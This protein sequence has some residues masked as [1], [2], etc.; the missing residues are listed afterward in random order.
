MGESGSGKTTP[1]RAERLGAA[2]HGNAELVRKRSLAG[3]PAV[4]RPRRRPSEL[5][6]DGGADRREN[7]EY[8]ARLAK[9]LPELAGRVDEL[10][11]RSVSPTSPT[12]SPSRPRSASSSEPRSRV[13]SSSHRASCSPTS[14]PVIRTPAG[15]SV[16]SSPC[17]TR[18]PAA[19]PVSSPRTTRRGPV[20]RHGAH[21]EQRPPR[22]ERLERQEPGSMRL[23]APYWTSTSGR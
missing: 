20:L 3:R 11:A 18:R 14:R 12:G 9:R 1:Q 4:A 6:A 5:R 21:D 15:R 7:V 22:R 8:P 13:P 23:G 19:R 16:F 17:G 2:G 10:L